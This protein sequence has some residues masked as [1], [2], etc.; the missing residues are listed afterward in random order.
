MTKSAAANQLDPSLF[1]ATADRALAAVAQLQ[2]PEP[3]IREWTTR[4]NAGAIQE[5]AEHGSGVARKAARRALNILKARGVKLPETRRVVSLSPRAEL[6]RE[7]WMLPPDG[8]GNV[9]FALT[10]RSPASRFQVAFL[11][12]HEAAG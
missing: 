4:S 2:D 11:V 3:L 5:V 1:D 6:V 8:V 10:A 12:I 9:L 7:A